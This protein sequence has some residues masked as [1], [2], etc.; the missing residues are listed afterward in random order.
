ML[1]KLQLL[2]EAVEEHRDGKIF[3]YSDV[4]I[5]FLQPI[6]DVAL[7]HLGTK[8]FVIQQGWP[9][10]TLCAG[11]FVMRGNE[12]TKRFI[13][14]AIELLEQKICSDDQIAMHTALGQ[15]EKGEIKWSLLPSSQFPNG[16]RILIKGKKMKV[17]EPGADIALNPSMVLFHANCC[18]GFENKYDLLDRVQQEYAKKVKLR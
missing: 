17:Y 9:R 13:R 12:K 15:F 11:F 5:I 7:T 8:D 4:D 1:R 10:Y 6:L 14:A 3:F 18:I 2:E 16:R